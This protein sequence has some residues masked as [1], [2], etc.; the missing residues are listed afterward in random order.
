MSIEYHGPCGASEL[1]VLQPA[2]QHSIPTEAESTS[3]IELVLMAS[4]CSEDEGEVR[5]LLNTLLQGEGMQLR[6]LRKDQ[7]PSA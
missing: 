5:V 3:F 6:D 2:D 1:D 4:E 7:I